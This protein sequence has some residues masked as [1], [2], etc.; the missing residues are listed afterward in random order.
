MSSPVWFQSLSL[1]IST[2]TKSM[3]LNTPNMNHGYLK[4]QNSLLCHSASK[5][6]R[7]SMEAVYC[8]GE[9]SNTFWKYQNTLYSKLKL[10]N[11]MIFFWLIRITTTSPCKKSKSSYLP[12]S[13]QGETISPILWG[14]T[15]L[16]YTL[17]T[18]NHRRK[19]AKS[20]H[21]SSLQ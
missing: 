5:Q 11:F 2:M 6:M 7:N 21:N 14:G 10:R 3:N 19:S 18:L 12:L 15:N 1:S 20:L 4:R 9:S 17:E 8:C 16:S 13:Y